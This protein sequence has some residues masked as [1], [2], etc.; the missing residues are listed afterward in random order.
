MTR[1]AAA[2]RPTDADDN[3]RAVI[4]G[5]RPPIE[6]Q[7]V[8]DLG[9]A[10]DGD[11]LAK[12]I[13][14]LLASYERAPAKIASAEIAG[15]YADMIKQ[16]SAAGK[17]V[18]AEREKLNRPLLNAQR[19]LKGRA[20]AV[21]A[22]L[23]DAEI[24]ARAR[25]KSFDDEQ[26]EIERKRIAE[27]RR[28]AEIERQRLQAIADEDA[29]QERLRLQAI[30]DEAARKE[31]LQLQAIEDARAAAEKRAAAVVVVEAE[32]VEVQAVVVEVAAP[33][34]ETGPVAQGDFGAKVNRVTTWHH[35]I[36]S[37]RQLPD[38]ILKHAKVIEALDK[39][40]AAQV[41]GG[42][43]EMKGVRIFSETGIAI[44]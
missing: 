17:A 20:D 3:P 15:R 34:A 2:N 5:N 37:V 30:A 19:A 11:G 27:E 24:G 12:R 43:R 26:A 25:V 14:D 1:I 42:T 29:R 40:I 39:V 32:A 7:I 22:P 8:I 41:R 28:K 6:E 38:A 13:A 31:R 9:E 18:E 33:K 4:G 23:K 36:L 35:E 16:M 10:L 21:T 44:R